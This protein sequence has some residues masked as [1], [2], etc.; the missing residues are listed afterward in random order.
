MSKNQKEKKNTVVFSNHLFNYSETFIMAQ[1]EG[2]A[3][4][5]PFYIGS[6]LVPDGLHPPSNRSYVVNTSLWGRIKDALMKLGHPLSSI[7][8]FFKSLNPN[9]IHAH[10]GPNGYTAMA[11]A[12]KLN[13]PLI[14]T[15]HGFD[16]IDKP[17][18]ATHGRLHLRYLKNLSRLASDGHTFIAVSDFVKRRLLSLGFDKNKVIRSYIGI[19]TDKFT[20]DHKVE[21]ENII[22]CV[23]RMSKYKGQEY[24]IR[25]MSELKAELPDFR[26]VL[27]GDGDEK[28][29]LERLAASLSVRVTFTGRQTQAQVLDWMRRAMVYVQ[30]SVTLSNGQEEALGLTIVEAQAVGTPCVV[31]QSGGMPEAIDIDHSGF[32]VEEKN[33]EALSQAIHRLV[34]DKSLWQTFSKRA[35]SF[36]IERHNLTKQ[37]AEIETIYDRVIAQHKAVIQ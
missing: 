30:P 35:R 3:R 25:S 16:L 9:L 5:Q 37:C 26:L 1:G 17:T 36:V 22:L 7:L 18:K 8:C 14:V 10:F 13:K 4:Y 11:I 23:G 19:D 2:L 20:P 34:C 6:S 27:V 21:R 32:V 15:F 33:V 24:L 29:S 12:K 31:F 28:E